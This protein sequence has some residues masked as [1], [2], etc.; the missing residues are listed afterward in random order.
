MYLSYSRYLLVIRPRTA[1]PNRVQ[2][3]AV[4]KKLELHR[5]ILRC[6]AVWSRFLGTDRLQIR[7]E[8]D[9]EKAIR[10]TNST[11]GILIATSSY[12]KGDIVGMRESIKDI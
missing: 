11:E 6:G 2:S 7:G 4:L 1:G 10:I 5:T 9:R 3:G 8:H 12:T